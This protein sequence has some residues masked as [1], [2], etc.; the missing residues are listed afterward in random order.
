M[1]A[2]FTCYCQYKCSNERLVTLGSPK[3]LI[4]C[5]SW[6][7]RTR[8]D[9]AILFQFGV[10]ILRELVLKPGAEILPSRHINTIISN[11]CSVGVVGQNQIQS[12]V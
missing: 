3:C 5:Y 8:D 9:D 6:A 11:Y 4:L 1:V 2:I 10:V 7:P 12:L